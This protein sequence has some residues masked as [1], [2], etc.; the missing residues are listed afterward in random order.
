MCVFLSTLTH[1]LRWSLTRCCHFREGGDIHCPMMTIYF[2]LWSQLSTVI[3]ILKLNQKHWNTHS[4]SSASMSAGDTGL[5]ITSSD[6]HVPLLSFLLLSLFFLAHS[7]LLSRLLSPHPFFLNCPAWE[8]FTGARCGL[9][10][11]C[12]WHYEHFH[13]FAD[14]VKLMN[15]PCIIYIVTCDIVVTNW[16]RGRLCC[17]WLRMNWQKLIT[18]KKD[19]ISIFWPNH[20]PPHFPSVLLLLYHQPAENNAQ[21]TPKR[22]QCWS[23][24]KPGASEFQNTHTH[25]QMG[26]HKWSVSSLRLSTLLFVSL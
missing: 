7:C 22:P 2:C 12:Q 11:D 4:F 9:S 13:P 20:M 10:C 5:F 16:H 26:V 21:S 17:F 23:G 8:E 3:T 1:S 14:G 24:G 18:I 25:T 6:S 15:F 19:I